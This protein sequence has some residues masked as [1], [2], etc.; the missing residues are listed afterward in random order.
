LACFSYDSCFLIFIFSLFDLR[1]S[2][3]SVPS[4]VKI[5]KEIQYDFNNF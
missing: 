1:A 3:F 2:V 4:V 5:E